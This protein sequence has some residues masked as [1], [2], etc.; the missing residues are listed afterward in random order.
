MPHTRSVSTGIFIGVGSRYEAPLEAGISHFIEHMCFKGTERRRTPSEL[1]GEIEGVGGILNAGTDKEMTI[2]WSKVA[3]PHFAVAMDV[4]TDMLVNSRFDDAD[5]EKERQVIIEEIRM[6]KDTPSQEV[7][8]VFDEIM[9][10]DHPLGTDTAGSVESVSAIDRNMMLDFMG[11]R[12]SPSS[13]VVSISGNIEHERAL[14]VVQSSFDRWNDRKP[15]RAYSPFRENKNPRIRVTK[16]ETEQAHF[17][18]GVPGVSLFDPKRFT[19]DLLNVI[20]GEGMSSRLFTEI[21]DNLGL[22]YSIYSYVDH[23]LD[24]GALTVSAGVEPKNL[25]RAVTVTLEQL[26]RVRDESIPDAEVNKA[27]ELSKGRLLLRMEDSRNVNGWVGGQEILTNRI[28]TID[29]VLAAIDSVTAEKMRDVA[30][31]LLLTERLRMAVVG[32]VSSE[33]HLEGLLKL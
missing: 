16:R 8:M 12:Y 18:L 14:E 21:R 11:R 19:L 33:D 32:P 22:A 9:W 28:M 26:R 20:L 5:I 17:C 6:T 24:S 27:K 30:R 25:A 4:L 7:N 31:E 15:A 23:F 3:Q 2:Y 13:V 10:P 1:S 29:E